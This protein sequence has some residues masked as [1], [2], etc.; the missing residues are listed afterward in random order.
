MS[1]TFDASSTGPVTRVARWLTAHGSKARRRGITTKRAI[2]NHGQLPRQAQAKDACHL[3]Q[4]RALMRRLVWK[5]DL[6]LRI[7]FYLVQNSRHG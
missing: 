6:N 5:I 7:Y 1:V 4:S 3:G 2:F